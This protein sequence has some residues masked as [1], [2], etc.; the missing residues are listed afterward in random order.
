MTNFDSDKV[1]IIHSDT[2]AGGKFLAHSLSLSSDCVM[3]NSKLAMM[4]LGGTLNQKQKLF[5]LLSSLDNTHNEWNHFGFNDIDWIGV[6]Y[7][8]MPEKLKV[9]DYYFL[10]DYEFKTKVY[11]NKEFQ[12]LTVNNTK[13]FFHT[14][15]SP[16][17][18]DKLLSVWKNAKVI[19]LKNEKLFKYI[20][21]FKHSHAYNCQHKLKNIWNLILKE[22]DINCVDVPTYFGA[23]DGRHFNNL[24][25]NVKTT[26][27]KYLNDSEFVKRV[28][29]VA[30][31]GYSSPVPK[32]FSEYKSLT[33]KQK[34]IL[35]NENLT[36]EYVYKDSVFVW[37]CNWY[38]NEE[39]TLHNVK[40][41]YNVLGLCEYNE[42]HSRSFYKAWIN[43]L[44]EISKID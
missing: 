37:D 9:I 28:N 17:E 42:S 1:I 25:K 11:T 35:E 24:P 41:I 16:E 39:N 13:Y 44:E 18:L 4:Q 7:T 10:N 12:Y 36:E 33:K 14:S 3:M 22:E 26:V 29:E 2:G 31:I 19:S 6:D 34:S 32:S 21:K 23:P 43:K 27:K 5:V 20:R 15:H 8:T 38:L 40:N 30:R